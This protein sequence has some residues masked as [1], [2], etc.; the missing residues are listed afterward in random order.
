LTRKILYAAGAIVLF[1][2]IVGV[3]LP[4]TG[5]VE[6]ETTIDAPAAT[7]FA[8]ITDVR[9][10]QEWSPWIASDPNAE[11]QFSGPGRGAGATIRWNSPISGSG[12]Q[13]IVES[14]P[15]ERVVTEL[16][17]WREGARSTFTLDTAEGGTRVR[18]TFDADFGIDLVARYRRPILAGRVGQSYEKGLANLK[19]MA[20][21]LPRADFSDLKIEHL[22]IE[23]AQ[24]AYFTTASLPNSAAISE[25]M[26]EAYFK[27][28]SFMDR[29][30][31]QEAG[32]P[33]SI[34]REFSG[35]RLVFDAAIPLR[36]VSDS[37]PQSANG[38]QL[39][40]SYGGPVIRVAH[41]GSYAGLGKT[42]EK[43]A[44]YLAA[45]GIER[46]G[47]AWESYMSD[48]TRTAEPELLTY[49]YYPVREPR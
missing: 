46:H 35:A 3:F 32:A 26:G 48:P 34:S 44:A 24:I 18:W 42:H 23:P 14:I 41:I 21:S 25:A 22:T 49:V 39:G 40:Q 36:G 31:L 38:V 11:P 16:N 6:R 17:S 27:V 15:V 1:A 20:E 2:V 8:L 45:Y 9:R 5:H 47:D 37:T 10:L 30:G 33:L 4:S 19:S 29:H 13:T 28:L 12:S 7:V 43:I